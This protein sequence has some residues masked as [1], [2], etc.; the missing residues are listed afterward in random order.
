MT[1]GSNYIII[2]FHDIGDKALYIIRN[3][4]LR[5]I[6]DLFLG[7]SKALKVLKEF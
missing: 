4:L 2:E 1:L 3:R 7:Y 5:L 6:K